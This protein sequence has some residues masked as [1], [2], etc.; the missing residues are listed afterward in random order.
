MTAALWVRLIGGYVDVP[1]CTG[2]S[3]KSS[4]LLALLAVHNHRVVTVDHIVDSL[5]GASAPRRP[6]AG[7]ATLVSRLRAKYVPDLIVGDRGGYRLGSAQVDLH[8]AAALITAAETMSSLRS[9]QQ[10]LEILSRGVVIDRAWAEP[11]RVLHAEMLR[12]GRHVTADL[13]LATDPDT[14]REL[15]TA[16]ITADP[17]DE[18]AY[19]MLIRAHAAMNQHRYA[20]DAYRDLRSVLST[21]LGID[22]SSVTRTLYRSLLTGAPAH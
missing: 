17:L 7:V 2:D 22:P 14:A 9:A 8:E 1:P 16:A 18:V 13:V 4:D 10:G 20:H 15:A 11:A 19:R 12:R 6:A 21:E 5:W 3:G